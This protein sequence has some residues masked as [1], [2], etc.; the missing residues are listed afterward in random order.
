MAREAQEAARTPVRAAAGVVGLTFLAVGVMGFVPGITAHYSQMKFAGHMSGA[1][2]LGLFQVS[3]LHN[4]VHVLFGVAG[5]AASRR[6]A[7]ASRGYLLGGGVVYLV[8]WIYGLVFSG[9]TGANFV[10]LNTADN[11]LHL[12]LGVGMVGLGVGLS[13]TAPA[14]AQ[15]AT[16]QSRQTGSA[17]PT[18]PKDPT[19]P[20]DPLDPTG[21]GVQVR[22]DAPGTGTHLTQ[23]GSPITGAHAGEQVGAVDPGDA[24]SHPG[25]GDPAGPI[26]SAPPSPTDPSH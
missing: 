2:L 13:R 14:S 11:W 18:D 22:G 10:P 7:A 26:S 15:A 24:G 9:N 25:Y 17:A 12:L 3:V 8:L 20:T 1:T 6:S 23:G 21:R 16:G 5:V 19:D 4:L